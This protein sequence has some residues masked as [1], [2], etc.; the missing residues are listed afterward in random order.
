LAA[1]VQL[2]GGFPV[3]AFVCLLAEVPAYACQSIAAGAA[4]TALSELLLLAALV[5]LSHRRDCKQPKTA[6][7][8][9]S[10]SSF[11]SKLQA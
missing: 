4:D 7:R 9:A 6:H 8:I 3:R 5:L 10:E 2:E 1:A 11:P